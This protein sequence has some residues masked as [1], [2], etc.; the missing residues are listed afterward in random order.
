[1]KNSLKYIMILL[2]V[3]FFTPS[4]DDGFAE[5]NQNPSAAGEINPDFQFA[6]VQLRTSGG[7]YE[8]W[9]ANLIYT[10]MMIQHLA[11]E[12]GYWTGDKYTYNAGYSSSLFDRHYS[13]V[14]KDL[15]D[16]IV[17]LEAG[18][19][20]AEEL[21]VAKIWQ[22]VAYQRLTDMYGDVP[23]SQAGKGFLEGNTT[24]EYD[25]QESIYNTLLADLEAAN[26]AISG[27]SVFG[28]GDFIYGGDASQWKRFGNSMMLRMGMRLS[29]K[30]PAAAQAWVGKAIAGGVMSSRD[31]DA[32]I[33]HNGGTDGIN[34]NGIGEVLDKANGFGDDCPRISNTFVNLL[35]GDPRLDIIAV[36]PASG[37]HTGM[38]NGLDAPALTALG[39]TAN[40]FDRIN[41]E[42]VRV[43]SPMFFMTYAETELLLAEAAMRGW[44]NGD[45][46]T[47]YE[48]GVRAAM[49]LFDHY[50]E[51]ANVADADIDAFIA[52]NPFDAANGM[53]QIANQYYIATFLNEYEA[54]SNWRRTGFPTL[55]PVDYPGNESNGQIPRRLR[56]P[57]S[58]YGING[59]NINAVNVRQGPDEFTT[60]VWWDVN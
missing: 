21:A 2:A 31:D 39:Q 46:G 8:N 37:V 20:S 53:E 17:S 14:S 7:R 29:G 22:A 30:D 15:T 52:A 48:N 58:E 5:L 13:D 6:W 41:P 47:H 18:A 50:P 27:G 40:D 1:M 49:K 54:F 60:R 45:A 38:P 24:P 57:T 10:S 9:R 3:V 36:P 19:G 28:S 42:I 12:C 4:C 33:L 23:F 59:D 25:T 16:L 26:G 43:T 32:F 34:F 56:Y 11:A 51:S 35:T 44:H 55:I